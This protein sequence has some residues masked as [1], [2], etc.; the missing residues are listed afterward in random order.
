MIV[1]TATNTVNGMQYVGVTRRKELDVRIAQHFRQAKSRKPSAGSF[2]EAI[3][4]YGEDSICFEIIDRVETLSQ[5]DRAERHWIAELNTLRPHG[6][7]LVCGGISTT[8]HW[9]FN[10]KLYEVDGKKYYGMQALADAYDANAHNLRWRILRSPEPWTIKQ[11]LGLEPPP[12]IDPLRNFNEVTVRGKK[13]KSCAHAARKY[14]V[15]IKKFRLRL[16]H[17][18]SPEEALEIEEREKPFTDPQAKQV[19]V[20]GKTFRSIKKA[21]EHYGLR[22]HSV[23]QRMKVSGWT[24]EEAL[25]VEPRETNYQPPRQIAGYA[26]MGEAARAH[27]IKQQTLS[28]RLKAGWAVEEALSIAPK[29]GANQTLRERQGERKW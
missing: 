29:I 23:W 13:F 5:L 19:T 20:Q 21:T 24:L 25:F 2:Q 8:P 7:N 3:L 22:Y 4:K 27:G 16:W 15:D 6:Y 9:A 10:N 14:G 26:S 28:R 17:G 12:P 1:Y 11:A 18:W